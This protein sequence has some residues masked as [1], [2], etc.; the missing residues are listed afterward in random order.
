MPAVQRRR[1]GAGVHVQD[2]LRLPDVRGEAVKVG[3]W[4]VYISDTWRVECYQS[5]PCCDDT[6]FPNP[7]RRT[8]VAELEQAIIDHARREHG[9]ELER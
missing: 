9:I 5:D 7:G 6:E 8:T 2:G 4:P 1:P 3:D